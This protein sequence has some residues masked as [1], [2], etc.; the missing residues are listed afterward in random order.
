MPIF[1]SNTATMILQPGICQGAMTPAEASRELAIQANDAS[2]V[3]RKGNYGKIVR[4]VTNIVSLEE[5]ALT[6]GSPASFSLFGA[7]APTNEQG[8]PIAH[9][10]L[11]ISA[12]KILLMFLRT[13][14]VT[15]PPHIFR[16]DR[17]ESLACD[18][19]P[20]VAARRPKAP[21][22]RRARPLKTCS[23]TLV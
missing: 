10:T 19:S 14:V 3:L 21:N 20:V 11:V 17:I 1:R 9:E 7:T 15:P 18:S 5:T 8:S 2:S 22:F 4:S 23:M 6:S 13:N 12:F 16:P